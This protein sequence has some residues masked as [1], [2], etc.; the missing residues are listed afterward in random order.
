MSK[1]K[2]ILDLYGITADVICIND[3]EYDWKI[4]I[5]DEVYAFGT[6]TDSC[7]ALENIDKYTKI[8]LQKIEEIQN[9]I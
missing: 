5:R 8:L 3:S 6:D 9:A 7:D 1:R 2:E 4:R